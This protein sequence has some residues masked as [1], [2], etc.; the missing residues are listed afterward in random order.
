MIIIMDDHELTEKLGETI[1]RLRLSK[2]VSQ[3]NFANLCGLHR[4]YIGAIERGEKNITVI[5]AKRISTALG[6]TL[7][8]L[9]EELESEGIVNE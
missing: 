4:T 6:L 1:R 8:Q 2:H 9:F 3:E 7:T 5:T